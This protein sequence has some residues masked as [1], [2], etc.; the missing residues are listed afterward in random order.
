MARI[1]VGDHIEQYRALALEQE[2]LLAAHC[3]D[4]GQRVVAIHAFGVHLVNSKANAQAR[5]H[6]VAHGFAIG[7]AAHA[8]LVIEN[9][10]QHRQ[11]ALEAFLPELIELAHGSEI[12]RLEHRAATQG[13]VADVRHDDAALAVHALEQ[14]RARRDARRAAHDGVVRINAKR[15][16]EGVHGAAQ[17]AVEA[18]LAGEDFRHGAIEQEFNGQLLHAVVLAGF[19]HAQG[20]AVEEILHDVHQGV[21]AELFDG[22]KALGEDFAVAAVGAKGVVVHREVEGLAD[23]RSFLAH[24]KVRRAGMVVGDAIV[25]ARG[26]DQVDHG[27]E[28]AQQE[29]IPVDVQELLAGEVAQLV[30]DGLL[31]S[32]QRDVVKRELARR[33]HHGGINE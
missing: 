25:L 30:L 21:V 32:I 28:L 12:Q 20:L 13:T 5:E 1:A 29:H 27:F 15:R 23:R 14:R 22:R 17:A 6:V 10:E 7:L 2:I 11:A 3:F 9:V 26:L 18:G 33:T 31:V 16:E 19:H 4:H 8:V 24:G